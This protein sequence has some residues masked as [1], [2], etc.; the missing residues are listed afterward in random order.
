MNGDEETSTPVQDAPA[1]TTDTPGSQPPSLPKPTAPPPQTTPDPQTATMPEQQPNAQQAPVVLHEAPASG[2]KGMVN[3]V[4][5]AI[6]G[7]QGRQVYTDDQGNKYIQHPDLTGPQKWM[8][9]ANYAI[10]GAAAGLAAGKGQGNMGRAPLAGL[11]A[12]QNIN[13]QQRQDDQQ[14][15]DEVRNAQIDKA[16]QQMNQLKL[17]QASLTNSRLQT[18]IGEE[19]GQHSRDLEAYYQSQHAIDLGTFKDATNIAD[20]QKAHP[21]IWKSHF[22]GN[23]VRAV[24]VTDDTGKVTATH[25][26]LLPQ[27]TSG[28]AMPQGSQFLV[29]QPNEDPAKP[30]SMQKVTP[31]GPMS[32]GEMD[33][34]NAA[35]HTAALNDATRIQAL[36]EAKS[37]QQLTEAQ[38]TEAG[39]KHTAAPGER[40]KTQAQ[41][42][43][44]YAAATKNRAEANKANA[45]ANG[46]GGATSGTPLASYAPAI[47]RTVQGLADYSVNP[48][49]FPTRVNAK[50]GQLDRETAVG[51]AKQL[52]PTYDETQFTSRNRTR[53]D[54][55]SGTARKTIN[56]LN[57]AVSHLDRLSQSGH[58]LSNG[59]FQTWNYLRNSAQTLTGDERVSN[60]KTDANAVANEMATV[61]KGTGATDQEI[62]TWKDR[63]SSSQSPR[64]IAGTMNEMLELMRGRLGAI[65]DQ[66]KQSMGKTRD[67]HILS[68]A[69][70]KILQKLGAND[71]VETDTSN[72]NTAPQQ[73]AA[74]QQRQTAPQAQPQQATPP[75]GATGK[76]RGSDGRDYWVDSTGKTYGV[77]P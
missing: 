56:A 68:P 12:G 57:T 49:T 30:G 17:A 52:D 39:D 42:A 28:E 67:F 59:N 26:V 48:A 62:K 36:S 18:Q 37:K 53:Q 45:E 55:A 21:E 58:Q 31:S 14:Q 10:Q 2:V 63:V 24:P 46:P 65:D 27:D 19:A 8:R 43:E 29:Y 22:N 15:D 76:A 74:P 38:V 60:F 3:R 47:Q 51:L 20:L 4:L 44:A 71:V 69:S 35:A 72:A 32:R 13:Q 77:A 75:Q 54:F 11:Q 1:S 34:Y 9:V 61:F 23:L 6:S 5:D 7:T 64:Q 73:Q 41:T 16:N 66:W 50:A 25:F 40:A 33:S 70:Q